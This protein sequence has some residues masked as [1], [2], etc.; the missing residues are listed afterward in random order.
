MKPLKRATTLRKMTPAAHAKATVGRSSAPHSF[1]RLPSPDWP[2]GNLRRLRYRALLIDPP[3]FLSGGV[4]GR[5]QHYRRMRDHEIAALPIR[6]LCHPEGAWIFVWCTSPKTKDFFSVILPAWRL[7][8]SG[9]AFLWVKLTKSQ[10]KDLERARIA[11]VEPA[12]TRKH[13]HKGMGLTTRKNPEDCWL[14]RIGK[15]KIRSRN[16]DEL[17]MAP[18]R[19]HSR[20]PD[21][22]RDR[23]IQF[24]P[25]PY[26][27]LFSRGDDPRWEHAGDEVG[28]FSHERAAA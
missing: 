22:T 19:E 17:I 27:E 8:F 26:A 7:Q 24:C 12:F 10:T 3:W 28:K 18:L 15:P 2:F 4:K 21:E 1:V 16:V 20:K 5:P 13:L 14:L 23:I 9:R 11:G 6:Q 25:G